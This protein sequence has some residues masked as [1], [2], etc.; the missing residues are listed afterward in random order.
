MK[1]LLNKSACNAVHWTLNDQLCFTQWNHWT[2]ALLY[3]HPL[4][5]RQTCRQRSMINFL[6]VTYSYKKKSTQWFTFVFGINSFFLFFSLLTLR[7]SCL[8]IRCL[9]CWFWE[10]I[11]STQPCWIACFI[12]VPG[13]YI[14]AISD[15]CRSN[16]II[17]LS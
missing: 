9:N 1:L 3:S 7:R 14:A 15:S 6:T 12:S 5:G 17:F 4:L 11:C 13:V 8:L 2:S 16:F 10:K